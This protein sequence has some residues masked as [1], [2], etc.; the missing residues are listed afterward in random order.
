MHNFIGEKATSLYGTIC[1]KYVSLLNLWYITYTK[2][3]ILHIIH[4]TTT[5]IMTIATTTSTTTASTTTILRL[6]FLY[7]NLDFGTM[8][9]KASNN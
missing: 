6:L 9:R 5:T 1:K 7:L 8:K 2:D 3:K 4:D